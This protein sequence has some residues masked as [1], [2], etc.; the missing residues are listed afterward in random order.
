VLPRRGQGFGYLQRTALIRRLNRNHHDFSTALRDS[1]RD[2]KT[3]LT[4]TETKLAATN[5]PLKKWR[6]ISPTHRVGRK[7]RR[8]TGKS[9]VCRAVF[10]LSAPNP[11]F[12]APFG[13]FFTHQS[14]RYAWHPI[15]R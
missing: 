7:I 11:E 4:A 6:S 1:I 15:N 14:I 13:G 10:A 8:K 5:R 2:R 3:T 9:C 12:I